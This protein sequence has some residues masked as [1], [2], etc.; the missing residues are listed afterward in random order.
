[1]QQNT[2]TKEPGAP[3]LKV[4]ILELIRVH[5]AQV[6]WMTGRQPDPDNERDKAP[7]S[8]E[9]KKIVVALVEICLS[10]DAAPLCSVNGDD[11]TCDAEIVSLNEKEYD[12]LV[13]TAI[14]FMPSQK[15]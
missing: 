1:M 10:H 6:L 15:L 2:N 9:G 13:G 14:K 7:L 11:G 4:L 3:D 12:D 5:D 8:E